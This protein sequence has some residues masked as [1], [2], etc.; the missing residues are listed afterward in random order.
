M[1]PRVRGDDFEVIRVLTARLR[2]LAACSARGFTTSLR[3]LQSEGAGKAG[4]ALH[5]RSRVQYAKEV[6]TR[7]YRSSGG[8]PAFP[9]RWFY[10]LFRALPGDRLSCHRRLRT[11]PQT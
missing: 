1:G 2:D 6:R 3:P 10:G 11:N 9:A 4:C 5:P 8:I 7:A